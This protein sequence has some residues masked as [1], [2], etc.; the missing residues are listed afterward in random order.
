MIEI[1]SYFS[2]L[3]HHC[4]AAF[5]AHARRASERAMK[6]VNG[7]GEWRGGGAALSR[8]LA[9][10]PSVIRMEVEVEVEPEG[11]ATLRSFGRP[12]GGTNRGGRTR[13]G[14]GLEGGKEGREAMRTEGGGAATVAAMMT[15]KR[16]KRTIQ[17]L[18]KDRS[19]L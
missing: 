9:L 17:P 15:R 3:A 4:S 6:A 7:N 10:L 14:K 13:T 5:R 2:H 1:V 12:L 16:R 8:P 19:I 18:L 11:K